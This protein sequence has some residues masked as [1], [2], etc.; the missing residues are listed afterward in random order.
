MS[1]ERT[2]ANR[3][4][5][6]LDLLVCPA[7]HRQLL[8]EDPVQRLDGVAAADLVCVEH[9]RV[10]V[11]DRHRPS[12][13]QRELGS[14]PQGSAADRQVESVASGK[15]VST[16]GRWWPIPEGWAGAG[17]P[18]VSMVVE[19]RCT[20]ARFDVLRDRWSPVVELVVDGATVVRVDL[21]AVGDSALVCS[22]LSS[23]PHRI[24]LRVVESKPEGRVVVTATTV[25]T[26]VADVAAPGLAPVDR[27]NPY[28]QG[29]LDL[30]AAAPDD[31]VVLDC[32]G[33][34]RR[35]GDARVFNLEY[36]PYDA[37]DLY[38]DGLALPFGEATFDLV[39]SQAVLEHVPD[40]Q[41]AV[42][43]MRRVLRPGG[44]IYCEIAF[45][46][47]LHAVPSHYFNVTPHGAAHLFRDW[48]VEI[49]DWFG[50]PAATI[51][52]WLRILDLETRWDPDKLHCFRLLLGEV[53]A[54]TSH[55]QLASFA[56]GVVVVAT[57]PR[58]L[59][60]PSQ[61]PSSAAG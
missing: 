45:T 53:D 57:P 49:L 1:D 28:P 44:R 58:W 31:A 13:L 2:L 59:R 38:A 33:G 25:E 35:C 39:L 15:M 52:W 7:C 30:L 18:G 19:T 36:L 51:D 21:A 8:V 40:P 29:F 20:G 47:P 6:L 9:G 42:D 5:G 14:I 56:S 27:G 46:Q 37:P 17:D 11:V 61:Q 22:G 32:G 54:L 60:S 55:D 10:G 23:G 43:E 48:D 16:S 24:E 12:F 50:G 41:R 4:R 34:D 26:S 3:Q